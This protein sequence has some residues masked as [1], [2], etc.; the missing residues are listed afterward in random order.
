MRVLS[1]LRTVPVLAAV[2]AC[3]S[4]S[5]TDTLPTRYNFAVIDGGNQA[6]V[7]GTPRLAKP[8]TSQLARDPAGKFA[9]S[10][11]FDFLFPRA[12][13]AQTLTV[14]GTPIANAIV[15]GREAAP[16]EPQVVPLCAFTLADGKAVNSVEPGTK[17]GTFNILF[18]AQVPSQLP[19]QD[20][21]TVTVLPGPADPNLHTV[22]ADMPVTIDTVAANAVVDE[23]GNP[24]P[25]AIQSDSLITVAGKVA[26]TVD[27]R[28]IRFAPPQF[29][30][31][32]VLTRILDANGKQIAIFDYTLFGQSVGGGWSWQAEG[33]VNT[34][35]QCRNTPPDPA[36]P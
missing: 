7:A 31:H 30:I 32:N 10:G 21:T 25:F 3:S 33:L 4:S 15:C 27:A 29:V 22:G 24:V 20:S 18:T 34:P 35:S 9:R 11:A 12:A 19:V 5:S 1:V 28:R 17:A 8:V 26:G 16:G 2:L 6:S 14:P 23:F 13:Y 36:C